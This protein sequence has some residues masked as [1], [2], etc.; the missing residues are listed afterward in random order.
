MK[1]TEVKI[2]SEVVKPI[3]TNRS[4]DHRPIKGGKLF[5][6]VA[7][8]VFLCARKNSGK[9]TV[10]K[11]IVS[12]CC[13]KN[14]RIIVFCSTLHTDPIW[15]DIRRWCHKYGIRF[16]GMDGIKDGKT[17]Q[18]KR[19]YHFINNERKTID[20][21]SDSDDP[22]L[23][24][25][26]RGEGKSK[27]QD[28]VKK[29]VKIFDS[30]SEDEE[31]PFEDDYS[32]DSFDPD[33]GEEELFGEGSSIPLKDQRLFTSRPESLRKK[34]KFRIPDNLFIF[35]DISSDLKLPSLVAMTKSNRHSNSMCIYSS[36]Y[37]HDLKPESIRNMD[38]IL[39]FKGFN[40]EKVEKLRV[41][42]DLPLSEE[43]FWR[44]YKHATQKPYSFLYVGTRNGQFRRNFDIELQLET[45]P[46]DSD[47]EDK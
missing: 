6:Q 32:E 25:E 1:I 31:G 24:R 43:A 21:D 34:E 42:A 2:N 19:I 4:E 15:K 14:T 33:D 12:T 39:L 3:R 28:K 13:G 30:D 47:A 11:K 7:P 20:S 40:R 23:E 5:D 8:N 45:P 38:F 26:V 36:Q 29:G 35:D 41:E 44:V 18:L 22:E 10:I 46:E 17:D 37:V 16:L 27:K 9:S